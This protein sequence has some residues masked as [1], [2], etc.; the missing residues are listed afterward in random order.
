MVFKD[1]DVYKSNVLRVDRHD[2][3]IFLVSALK[4]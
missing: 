1:L 4:N 3:I 2:E